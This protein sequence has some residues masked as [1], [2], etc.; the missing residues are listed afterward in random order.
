[1]RRLFCDAN[2]LYFARSNVHRINQQGMGKRKTNR[3]VYNVRWSSDSHPCRDSKRRKEE[4]NP[5]RHI[6]SYKNKSKE[7]EQEHCCFSLYLIVRERSCFIYTHTH[8]H[9]LYVC[10]CVCMMRRHCFLLFFCDFIAYE[11]DSGGGGGLMEEEEGKDN[12][13]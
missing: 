10:V 13:K 2:C 4:K 12:R 7:R 9:I 11:D 6:V 5:N 3:T 1:M 8:F